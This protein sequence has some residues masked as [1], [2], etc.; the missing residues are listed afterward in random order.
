MEKRRD[1][2]ERREYGSAESY[3]SDARTVHA[4]SYR[5]GVKDGVSIIEQWTGSIKPPR[6]GINYRRC[7]RQF[8]IARAI[9]ERNIRVS[10]FS[11]LPLPN[12]HFLRL[13]SR[14]SIFFSSFYPPRTRSFWSICG[15]ETVNVVYKCQNAKK[16]YPVES[17]F[18]NFCVKYQHS[19]L[20]RVQKDNKRQGMRVVNYL[21]I[22]FRFYFRT[23][24]YPAMRFTH[25]HLH[26]LLKT[27]VIIILLAFASF[28]TFQLL[29]FVISREWGN[30]ISRKWF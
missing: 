11:F 15:V 18:W 2:I 12:F 9:R 6:V 5:A 3:R 27:I 28:L 17:C 8:P 1:R 4:A 20:L 21:K 29:V 24:I 25:L 30:A 19:T 22:Y 26:F 10:G 7:R 14:Y 16:R 23:F 13:F